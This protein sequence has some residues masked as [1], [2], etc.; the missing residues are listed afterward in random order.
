MFQLKGRIAVV[1]GAGSGIGRAI[2]TL[3]ARQGAHAVVLDID[4]A[5]ARE[6]AAA[7]REAGG[8]ADAMRCDV[9][10]ASDVRSAFDEIESK[11]QG[12]HILVNNAGIAHVGAIERT[13]EADLDRVYRVNVKGVYL[14]SQAALPVMLRR[15]SHARILSTMRN[16]IRCH[17]PQRATER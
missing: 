14:C 15:G 10:E 12:L 4:E 5:A 16:F 1:T 17:H 7:I 6:T 2:A 11:G 13:T 3:F 8:M 9:A